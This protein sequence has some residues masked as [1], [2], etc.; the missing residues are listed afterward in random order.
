VTTKK[1]L[2]AKATT[3]KATTKG[4]GAFL[5]KGNARYDRHDHFYRRAKQEGFAARSVYKLDELDAE[6][7]LIRRGDT[8][9]D[10]GCAPGSWLQY[11][12]QK[13]GEGGRAYG[14][15][16]LPVKVAFPP[17][18]RV[19]QGDAFSVTLSDLTAAAGEHDLPAVDVV[20]SDMAP[21]LSGV[22][23]VDQGRA[24]NLVELALYMADAWLRTGGSAAI[25]VFQ[26]N[27]Y[28]ECLKTMR[29]KFG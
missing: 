25:K 12:E 16:L 2:P 24:Y 26:G 1:T 6:F 4:G 3:T 11:V 13:I 28:N 29:E 7:K 17:R 9:I 20:L 22:A 10:L 8:V 18:V 23:L 21:N 15:D 27:G 5:A 19:L 14:I